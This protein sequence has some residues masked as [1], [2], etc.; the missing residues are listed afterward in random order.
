MHSFFVAFFSLCCF[1]CS[2]FESS[3]H[4][5]ALTFYCAIH[6]VYSVTDFL[7][8]SRLNWFPWPPHQQA[9]V[10]SLFGS[11]KGYTSF[12]GEGAGEP[13]RT[14]GQTLWYSSYSSYIKFNPSTVQILRALLY[15]TD[16]EAILSF[17]LSC[18]PATNQTA[19]FLPSTSWYGKATASLNLMVI[20]TASFLS[21]SSWL[22]NQLSHYLVMRT[23]ISH[24]LFP[25]RLF[26]AQ[27]AILLPPAPA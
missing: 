11:R 6:R 17:A 4:F 20:Q 24:G 13:V 23:A 18:L 25:L 10:A 22:D 15:G 21:S 7:S 14:K 16:A 8:K 9:S 1:S 3:S 2:F 19:S 26:M 27:A 5:V 12:G